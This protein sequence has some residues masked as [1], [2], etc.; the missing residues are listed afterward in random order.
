VNLF[1]W[2]FISKGYRYL[3]EGI[4]VLDLNDMTI[5]CWLYGTGTIWIKEHTLYTDLSRDYRDGPAQEEFHPNG[6]IGYC[7]YFTKSVCHRPRELGPAK[8]WY[9]SD[10]SRTAEEYW[11]YGRRI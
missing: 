1:E 8:L 5:T 6:Q 3:S 4:F 10:G 2:E 9:D 11:E 7:G